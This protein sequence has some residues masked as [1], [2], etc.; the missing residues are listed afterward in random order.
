[1]SSNTTPS[2][3]A[4]KAARPSSSFSARSAKSSM[5]VLEIGVVRVLING[6]ANMVRI[7]VGL[8][9]ESKVDFAVHAMFR[10][11]MSPDARD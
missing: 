1:M 2:L 7:D 11:S 4:L 8:S 9:E 6:R 3:G 10:D 5:E